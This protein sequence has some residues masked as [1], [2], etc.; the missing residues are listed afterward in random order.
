MQLI[1]IRKIKYLFNNCR[2]LYFITNS[3]AYKELKNNKTLEDFKSCCVFVGEYFDSKEN[4]SLSNFTLPL[5]AIRLK[6]YSPLAKLQ[7]IYADIFQILILLFYLIKDYKYKKL[8]FT[9]VFNS[10]PLYLLDKIIPRKINVIDWQYKYIYKYLF[11]KNKDRKIS[12]KYGDFEFRASHRLSCKIIFPLGQN[13]KLINKLNYDKN[14]DIVVIHNPNR[15]F[16]FW[17][18]LNNIIENSKKSKKYIFIIHPKT[19]KS[20]IKAF[21]DVFKDNSNSKYIY[22]KTLEN[23]INETDKIRISLCYSLSSSLD[24]IFYDKNIPVTSPLKKS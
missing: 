15:S 20:D 16:E 12:F 11:I 17:F 4:S 6:P 9:S 2:K 22:F 14:G 19:F 1:V 5:S 23:Y 3:I 13:N 21:K 8:I 24:F 10:R 7:V 18:N